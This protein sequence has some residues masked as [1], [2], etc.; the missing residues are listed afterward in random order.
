[1]IMS[2]A[3]DGRTNY[4]GRCMQILPKPLKTLSTN[5]KSIY[6][7]TLGCGEVLTKV[8][9]IAQGFGVSNNTIRRILKKLNETNYFNVSLDSEYINRSNRII[10][11]LPI[12]CATNKVWRKF[13][14]LPEEVKKMSELEKLFFIWLCHQKGE[15]QFGA[16]KTSEF[17]GIEYARLFDVLKSLNESKIISMRYGKG[18]VPA[19]YRLAKK[20][21]NFAEWGKYE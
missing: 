19:Q 2:E 11:A 21:E 8:S 17:L 7:Y 6:L 12:H 20:Y 1:M 16:K 3:C 5:A 10:K 15:V 18:R 14:P 9:D 4:R 13:S